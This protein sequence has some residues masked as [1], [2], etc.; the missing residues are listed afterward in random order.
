MSNRKR[1][2]KVKIN[3]EIDLD[4]HFVK[5]VD[6]NYNGSGGFMSGGYRDKEHFLNMFNDYVE[7]Y[8]CLD[9]PESDDKYGT[10]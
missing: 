2:R 3:I 9:L 1:T 5:V 8:I 10:R 4:K 6:Y 7:E